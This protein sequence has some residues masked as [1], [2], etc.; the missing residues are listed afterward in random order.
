VNTDKTTNV[1]TDVEMKI[2]NLGNFVIDVLN[3]NESPYLDIPVRTLSNVE[4]DKENLKIVMK[5]KKSRRNFLNIAHTR[6]FTQTPPL[7][8]FIKN[9]YKPKKQHRSGICFIC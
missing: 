4:F 3:T 1:K 9:Y 6:K 5:D 8:S 2:R 7:Q